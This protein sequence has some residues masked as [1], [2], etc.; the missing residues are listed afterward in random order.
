VTTVF[1]TTIAPSEAPAAN[2]AFD[3]TPHELITA[4]I[5]DAG[6]LEPP[7]EEAIA[8]AFSDI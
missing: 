1:G 6:V 5:T 8:R 2:F 3:V 7:F 4:I